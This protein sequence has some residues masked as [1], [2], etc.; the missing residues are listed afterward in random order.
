[1]VNVAVIVGTHG[2]LRLENTQGHLV[3]FHLAVHKGR[4]VLRVPRYES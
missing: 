3:E 4:T 2:V 1:M